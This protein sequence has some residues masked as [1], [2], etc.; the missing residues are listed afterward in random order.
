VTSSLLDHQVAC[1]AAS[2]F[3]NDSDLLLCEFY[4]LWS[5]CCTHLCSDG[6]IEERSLSAYQ[7]NVTQLKQVALYFLRM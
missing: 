2:D 1:S 5:Y 3:G 4:F 7:L 6:G